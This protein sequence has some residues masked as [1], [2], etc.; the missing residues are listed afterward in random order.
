MLTLFIRIAFVLLALFV[1]LTSG[2]HF[3][4]ESDLPIWFSGAMGF[5]IAIT[6][7][8]TEHAFRR[9]FNRSLVAFLIGLA[10]GLILSFLLVKVLELALPKAEWRTHV[11][12][13]T[14]LITTYLVLIVVLRNADRFRVVVPFVEFRTDAVREGVLVLD[15]SALADGRLLGLQ[16]VGLLDQRV[17]VHRR[18]VEHCEAMSGSAEVRERLRGQRA[19]RS[20]RDLRDHLGDG[21]QIDDSD[22]PQAEGLRDLLIGLARLEGA[23]L[24]TS[25]PDTAELARA[26]G[27]RVLDLDRLARSLA[28]LVLPGEL[29]EVPLERAGESAG[30]AVGYLED[31]SMVVVNGGGEAIGETITASVVRIHHTRNGRMVFADRETGGGKAT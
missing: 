3:Y 19:I 4:A 7:I 11:F 5:A 26:E 10:A 14:T 16:A 27:L 12:L 25:D 17:L 13:P 30:Q 9:H 24:V 23:R 15:V 6:I 2:N 18:V 22:L 29:V 21:L 1:G 20:L 8:A 28:P 31:G